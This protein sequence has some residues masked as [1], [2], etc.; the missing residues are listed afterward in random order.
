[1]ADEVIDFTN[2]TQTG[3]I[4]QNERDVGPSTI[5][6]VA[7]YT[8]ANRKY[9][10]QFSVVDQ[11][12]I[13]GIP[14][15]VFIDNNDNPQTVKVEVTLTGQYFEAP[16][17]SSGFYTVN[18]QQGSTVSL[19][20]VGGASD[21]SIITFYNTLQPPVVWYKSGPG[22]TSPVQVMGED[23]LTAMSAANPFADDI[24]KINGNAVQVGHGV[25]ASA[26]RVELPT[27]GNGLVNVAGK[28]GLTKAIPANPVAVQTSFPFT[29]LAA[30]A[31]TNLKAGAGVLG[32]V[33][34]NTKGT[35]A[36]VV[37]LYDSLTGSGSVIAIIDSLNLSGTFSF[38]IEFAVGLTVVITGTVA[39]DITVSYR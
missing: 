17:F 15:T 5:N 21:I 25:A 16:A 29:H 3:R 12:N 19:E 33:I 30:S 35:V 37:T 6:L 22:P 27:D 38:D 4:Q 8:V 10:A 32:K 26:L 20:S 14:R 39:P 28:D 23:G 9:Q 34:V 31:T 18:A 24:R 2:L 1:M 11:Q 36:S 13:F 7:D